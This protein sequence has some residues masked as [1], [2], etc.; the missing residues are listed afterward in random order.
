MVSE[1]IEDG[2]AACSLQNLKCAHDQDL[3]AAHLR[4][5]GLRGSLLQ[6]VGDAV[7]VG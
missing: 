4:G 2:N 1:N 6:S 3:S 5:A 7:R